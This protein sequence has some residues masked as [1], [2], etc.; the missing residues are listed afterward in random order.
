[1]GEP[2]SYHLSD[3]THFALRTMRCICE[4]P[5]YSCTMAV[6]GV[7]RVSCSQI[8]ELLSQRQVK[9]VQ[10]LLG[11]QYRLVASLPCD[12]A[13]ASPQVPIAFCD[14]H[15]PLIPAQCFLNM[16]PAP[17]RYE[18]TITLAYRGAGRARPAGSPAPA[19]S[20]GQYSPQGDLSLQTG[21]VQECQRGLC[22]VT[23]EGLQLIGAGLDLQLRIQELLEHQDTHAAYLVVDFDDVSY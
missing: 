9:A 12:T 15:A 1:M 2:Y 6:T 19:E 7:F 13:P 21:S 11:R 14:G 5:V 10:R 23:A 4:I 16:P 22:E 20:N 8:R 17:G 3:G 18:A